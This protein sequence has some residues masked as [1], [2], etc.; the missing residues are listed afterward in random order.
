MREIKFRAWD[1]SREVME[2]GIQHEYDGNLS[3]FGSYLDSEFWNVMQYTGLKDINDREIYEGDIVKQRITKKDIVPEE[4]VLYEIVF[5]NGMFTIRD[6]NGYVD[7]MGIALKTRTIEVIGNISEN[8][9][10]LEEQI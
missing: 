8:P 1:N 6:S 5:E 4:Y 3:C 2:Y 9:E 10:L 7:C